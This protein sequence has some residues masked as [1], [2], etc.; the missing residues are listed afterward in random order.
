VLLISFVRLV[1]YA[2]RIRV[3]LKSQLG[4]YNHLRILL[5]VLITF[6]WTLSLSC[7]SHM[8]LMRFLQLLIGFLVLLDLFLCILLHLHLMFVSSFLIIGFVD[9]VSLVKSFVIEML[10]FSLLFGNHCVV[11]CK[12]GLL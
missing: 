12:L 1:L 4:F 7:L 10:S 3:V 11:S 5:L 8:V 6:L 9:L 2:K